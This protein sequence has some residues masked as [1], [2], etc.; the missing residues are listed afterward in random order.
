MRMKT[1]LRACLVAIC[2]GV[3]PALAEMPQAQPASAPAAAAKPAAAQ[4]STAPATPAAPLPT[5]DQILDKYVQAS[6]GKE[7]FQKLTSQVAKGTFE[8]DQMGSGTQEIYAK[9]PNKV[10]FVT[11]LP[12]FGVVQRGY[13]G[14]AGWQDNPQTGLVDETGDGLAALK[15]EADFY[16]VIRLKDD[17]PK[18]TVKGKESISGHDAYVVEGIPAEGPPMTLSFD[19]DSGLLVRAQT[20]I[21]GP[22]GKADIVNTLGDYRE[23]DGV[24]LPFLVHSDMGEISFT[25][26]LSEIKHNVDIDDAKFNKPAAASPAPTQ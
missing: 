2:A 14:T 24:K 16:R 26:K 10:L 21:D 17:Y 5:V 18:M 8:L 25:I 20:V 7:A 12:S 6:G 1:L 23:V 13:N 3:L 19:A 9:A 22:M 15:I 4:A 11:D